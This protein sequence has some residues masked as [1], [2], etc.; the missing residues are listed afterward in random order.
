MF[1]QLTF[2][3]RKK[4]TWEGKVAVTKKRAKSLSQKES[5]ERGKKN[6]RRLTRELLILFI[7]F[8]SFPARKTTISSKI[9]SEVKGS[10]LISKKGG[11]KIVT[12]LGIIKYVTLKIF[13]VVNQK[14]N[15]VQKK[16]HMKK[17][18]SFL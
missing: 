16:E 12:T 2:Q 6:A 14:K 1:K 5:K 3:R 17:V 4:K 7:F 10:K 13:V 11:G 15:Y 18:I 9:S 8:C